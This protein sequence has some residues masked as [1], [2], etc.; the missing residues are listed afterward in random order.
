MHINFVG[1]NVMFD[2]YLT[3]LFSVATIYGSTCSNDFH[4]R[5]LNNSRCDFEGNCRCLPG[6]VFVTTHCLKGKF[7]FFTY[8]LSSPEPMTQGELL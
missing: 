8:H 7:F 6:F 1:N 3:A 2:S 4:C 5:L